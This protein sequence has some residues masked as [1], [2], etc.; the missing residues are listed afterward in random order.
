M[1][2]TPSPRPPWSLWLRNLM[3][4]LE[5]AFIGWLQ[6]FWWVKKDL[7]RPQAWG[8]T[9]PA[10][11]RYI[12]SLTMKGRNDGRRR[13]FT[14]NDRSRQD[15]R[16]GAVPRSHDL[17]DRGGDRRLSAHGARALGGTGD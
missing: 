1:T 2:W 5:T 11:P 13:Q 16:Q 8:G 15:G 7:R 4:R 14:R 6:D 9:T 12:H 3:L 17:R 10:L